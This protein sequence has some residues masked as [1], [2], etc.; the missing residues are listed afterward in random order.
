MLFSGR[1][2]KL[3]A[4]KTVQ[5]SLLGMKLLLTFLLPVSTLIQ[6]ASVPPQADPGIPVDAIN[7]PSYDF[8]A[9]GAGN[10]LGVYGGFPSALATFL[11]GIPGLGSGLSGP[12]LGSVIPGLGSGLSGLGSGLPGLGS[13][14]S[15]LESGLPGLGSG[16]S[17]L[18]SGLSGPTF[19]SGIPGSSGGFPVHNF[20]SGIPGFNS[21]I[22][23]FGGFSGFNPYLNGNS[24]FNNLALGNAFGGFPENY[25]L[26]GFS[27]PSVFINPRMMPSP[28]YYGGYGNPFGELGRLPRIGGSFYPFERQADPEVH[29]SKQ[30][31]QP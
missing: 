19:G 30:P 20:G 23:P 4:G 15:G 8:M 1:V 13:G 17:G 11:S 24:G 9:L 7:Y 22:Y 5:A 26:S 12:T 18:G 14:L 10:P 16:L 28:T 31:K 27:G 21:F 25:P 29:T 6:S 3:T 2:F